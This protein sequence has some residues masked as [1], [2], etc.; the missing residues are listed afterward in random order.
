MIALA[1]SAFLYAE[2][3]S[4]CWAIPVVGLNSGD[5]EIGFGI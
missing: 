3:I 1:C 5:V 2:A 4:L